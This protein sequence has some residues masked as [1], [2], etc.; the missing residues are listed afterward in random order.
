[1]ETFIK[2][3]R[4]F[5][6][7]LLSFIFVFI[8][9][10]V[11]PLNSISQIATN[12]DHVKTWL[13]ESNLYNNALKITIDIMSLQKN[14]DPESDPGSNAFFTDLTKKISDE[15]SELGQLINSLVTPE[16]LETSV[17][18]V[19]DGSYDFLE[20][21]TEKP[22]F[23]IKIA[24][25]KE[26]M[27]SIISVM[28]KEKIRVLPDCD[29][30]FVRPE[31][32]NPFVM[33]C[34]PAGFDENVIVEFISV[35]KDKPEL[36]TLIES[37]KISSDMISIDP[38][39]ARQIQTGFYYLRLLPLISLGI[40]IIMILLLLLITPG[41]KNGLIM[42]GITLFFPSSL[43]LVGSLTLRQKFYDLIEVIQMQLPGEY[44]FIFQSYFIALLKTVYFDTLGQLL[45]FSVLVFVIAVIL[46]ILG[47]I[48]HPKQV[49]PPQEEPQIKKNPDLLENTLPES[50]HH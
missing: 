49:L 8:I 21:K 31:D 24:E 17:N 40:L 44:L 5:I 3:I 12:R 19:I 22:I 34:K 11:I 2:I 50:I 15:D 20:G 47:F 48:Y 7:L 37:M 42:S 32:L 26:T 6:S 14:E 38:Q 16:F 29:P 35:N 9:L 43:V 36:D 13:Q 1:M 4:W 39:L 18:K 25:D 10:I 23:E 41:F 46:F 28:F 33:E 27:I 30:N 45:I